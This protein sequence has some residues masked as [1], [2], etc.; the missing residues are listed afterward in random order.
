V[1][2]RAI[3]DAVLVFSTE[4]L[5]LYVNSVKCNAVTLE[6]QTDTGSGPGGGHFAIVA[7]ADVRFP[8]A[9]LCSDAEPA[10]V[11]VQEIT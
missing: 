10:L 1:G 8:H 2:P 11:P 5:N 6:D 7:G 9:S 3:L 4:S